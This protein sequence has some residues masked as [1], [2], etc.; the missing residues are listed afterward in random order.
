MTDIS[1]FDEWVSIAACAASSRISLAF[2]METVAVTG[3]NALAPLAF[4]PSGDLFLLIVN[5]AQTFTPADGSIALGGSQILWGTNNPY[6]VGTGDAVVAVY[7][8]IQQV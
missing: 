6:S 2:Q 4:T 8:Y 3:V 1:V 7:T 5:G